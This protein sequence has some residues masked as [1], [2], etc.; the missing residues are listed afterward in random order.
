MELQGADVGAICEADLPEEEG[1]FEGRFEAECVELVEEWGGF[2]VD[3]VDGA[4]EAGR[5]GC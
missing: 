2:G 5:G 1:G 4:E 3:L